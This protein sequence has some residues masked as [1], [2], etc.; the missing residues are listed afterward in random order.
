MALI[1]KFL[2]MNFYWQIDQFVINLA[3]KYDQKGKKLLDVGAGECRYRQYFKNLSYFSQDIKQ[4][5]RKTIDYVKK[6]EQVSGKF[7]YILCTQVLE[8]LIRPEQAF[9]EFKRLLK[10]GGRLFLTTNFIYQIHMEP[11]DYWRFTEYGLR[12]LGKTVGFKEEKIKSQGGGFQV[13]AYILITLP[14]KIGLDHWWLSYWLYIILFSPVIM[15]I[16]LTAVGL[17]RIIKINSLVI[18]YEAIYES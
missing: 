10:P 5:S 14:L 9:R 11:V 15:L 17:D 6:L 13:L 12:F 4:N 16:N 3:K 18:N 8:H 7:D 1:L 2:L